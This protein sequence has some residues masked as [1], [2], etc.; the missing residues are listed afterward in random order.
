MKKVLVGLLAA[1]LVISLAGVG[2][3]K[4]KP[5]KPVTLKAKPFIFDPADSG[6]VSAAWVTHKG[7]PDAGKSAHAL[8]L[9]KDGNTAEMP[10]A[11]A[12]IT[13]VQGQKLTTLGFDMP[14]T[15]YVGDKAPRFVV[16]TPDGAY[17]FPCQAANGT[18]TPVGSDWTNVVFTDADAVL[19]PGTTVAW[20]G[21]GTDTAIVTSIFIM[22]D[23][24]IDVNPAGYV[25]LDNL[26]VN[27]IVMGKPGNARAPK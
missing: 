18:K 7:L 11:G 25:I 3:A 5:V 16:T 9:G 19:A 24:G 22:Y 8:Y 12:V 21:F 20:P 14:N 13:G 6:V 17:Y 23:D 26:N 15:G 10:F 4:A 2:F 1:V 27:G